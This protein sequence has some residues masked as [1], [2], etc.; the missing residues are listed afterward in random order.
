M[1]QIL[2]AKPST[3]RSAVLRMSLVG[4]LGLAAVALGNLGCED[5]GIGRPCDLFTNAGPEQGVFNAQALEC[6]SRICLKP[7]VQS[8]ARPPVP[9]TSAY[10]SAGCSQDS[11]CDGQLRDS[12]NPLDERCKTGFSCGIPFVKGGIC[13]KKLCV[14][15]D[16]LAESG[17]PEPIACRGDGHLTCS[18]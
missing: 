2:S 17:I 10:C 15:K 12:S 14:C 13:C 11:D 8:G 18:D 4:A 5:K 3:L 1:S 7:A 16:F 6:P 9:M